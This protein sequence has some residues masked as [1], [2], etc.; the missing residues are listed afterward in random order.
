[1]NAKTILK[2]IAS[3]DYNE[4]KRLALAEV[5]EKEVKTVSERT[6]AKAI[7]KLSLQAAKNKIRPRFAGAYYDN[8]FMCITDGYIGFVTSRKVSGCVFAKSDGFNVFD[9]KYI[10]RKN[11]PGSETFKKMDSSTVSK[12]KVFFDMAKASGDKRTP[13]VKI[14]NAYF[15]FK[16]FDSVFKCFIDPV[17]S[18]SENA[19]KALILKDEFSEGIVLSTRIFDTD[20]EK[21]RYFLIAEWGK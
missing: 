12:I 7:I 3:Q 19:V 4:L 20:E 1:M 8:D 11:C 17:Y 14:G 21:N 6:V 13:L 15:N 2:L 16:L 5:C 9:L 18:V 10:I